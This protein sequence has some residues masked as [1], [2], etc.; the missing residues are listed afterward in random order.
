MRNRVLIGWASAAV[1]VTVC[2]F[3]VKDKI[4]PGKNPGLPGLTAPGE[5]LFNCQSHGSKTIK[6]G[7]KIVT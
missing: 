4:I 7:E 5:L 6:K 2:F 1:F 3:L